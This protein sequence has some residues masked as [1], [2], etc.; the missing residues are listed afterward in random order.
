MFR[1]S[2][3]SFLVTVAVGTSGCTPAN[4]KR[5]FVSVKGDT[6]QTLGSVFIWS[7][8]VSAAVAYPRGTDRPPI[9]MQRAMTAGATSVGAT[10]SL[11]DTALK[12]ANPATVASG[13]ELAAAS[14]AISNAVMALSVSTE[15]T[16]YL[17]TG[18]FYLCQLH[19]NGALSQSQFD[20]VLKD[21]ISKSATMPTSASTVGQV[22][23]EQRLLQKQERNE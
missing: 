17:D 14:L 9:C 7:N 6:T 22:I 13:S 16:A 2:L 18:M 5:S 11:S 19:A 4:F 20:A 12:L 1:F 8:D 3:L 15:R 21:L 23:S 10:A